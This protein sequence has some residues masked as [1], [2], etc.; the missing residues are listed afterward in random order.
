MYPQVAPA[1]PIYRIT[2]RLHEGRTA[3]VP[4]SEIPTIV[5]SWLAELG[6]RSP[7]VHDL[8]RAVGADDWPAAYVIGEFLSVDVTVATSGRR[9]A[10]KTS[11]TI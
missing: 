7:L 6:V 5:S 9:R 8:A 3:D 11:Q 4:C 2:H 10:Q 1:R